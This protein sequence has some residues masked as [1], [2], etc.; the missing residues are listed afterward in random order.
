IA[1]GFQRDFLLW[2]TSLG[3]HFF[4]KRWLAKV[5]VYDILNQNLGVRRTITP[6]AVTDSENTVLRRYVM[7]SLTYKLD[8]FGGKQEDRNYFMRD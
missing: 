1:P 6:T 4:E 7:F 8:K 3:M 2:N 5:K